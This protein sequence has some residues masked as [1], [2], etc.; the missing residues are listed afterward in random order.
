MPLAA[1]VALFEQ[2]VFIYINSKR[3]PPS[4]DM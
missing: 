1:L 2:I 4:E 3:G